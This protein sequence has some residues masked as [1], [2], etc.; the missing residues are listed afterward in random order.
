MP[1]EPAA[2][3]YLMPGDSARFIAPGL[4]FTVGGSSG[5]WE[6]ATRC[7]FTAISD[8]VTESPVVIEVAAEQT[9]DSLIDCV[10]P[11]W[12][13]RG[14]G[15]VNLRLSLVG[16]TLATETFVAAEPRLETVEVQ[17][18]VFAGQTFTA[19]MPTG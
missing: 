16:Q 14:S 5:N 9:T 1:T 12:P 4:P 17:T 19:R 2:G 6:T 3:R 10:R 18:P 15:L 13:H 11:T 8:D 7:E